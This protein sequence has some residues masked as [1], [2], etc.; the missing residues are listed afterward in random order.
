MT[1]QIDKKKLK[2]VID[3]LN[4]VLAD[5]FVLYYKTHSSHW[6]VEGPQF[7]SLHDLF[8]EQY[9][10]IWNALDLLAERLRALDSYAPVSMKDLIKTASLHEFGQN[11]DAL[12]MVRD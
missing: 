4:G 9:T 1:K 3:A 7:K 10:E 6:N 8:M 5:S 11:R 2:H 12:Q